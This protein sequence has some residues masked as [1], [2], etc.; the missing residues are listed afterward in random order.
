MVK[1][2]NYP[3]LLQHLYAYEI[4]ADDTVVGYYMYGFRKIALTDCPDSIGENASDMSE[5]CYTL[6][7]RYIA[8]ARAYQHC[9]FGT[10]ALKLLI[11]QTRELCKTWPV[12][13]I[14]LNALKERAEWY[15]KIGFAMFNEAD[16]NSP[17]ADIEMY[18]DCLIDEDRLSQYISDAEGI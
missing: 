16:M 13:L 8:I 10:Y 11:L 1:R 17:E 7:I 3:T 6:H 9:G 4:L 14:T 18:I 2:S 5:Y 12:R 15:K